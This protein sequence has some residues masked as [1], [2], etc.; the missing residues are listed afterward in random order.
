MF[1]CLISLL[2][3]PFLLISIFVSF[4][5]FYSHF[6][7][8]LILSSECFLLQLVTVNDKNTI[9]RNPLNEGSTRLIHLYLT[10]H[11]THNR[12][13]DM[14]PTVLKPTIPSK[15]VATGTRLRLPR[16]PSIHYVVNKEVCHLF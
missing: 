11:N 12:Q 16:S 8:L 1:H 3:T 10:T 7:Y 13:T 6:L 15:Q 5:H 14:L 2:F 4:L 9:G